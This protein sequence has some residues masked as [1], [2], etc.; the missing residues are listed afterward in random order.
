MRTTRRTIFGI[1]ISFFC[2]ETGLKDEMIFK[3][4]NC[5]KVIK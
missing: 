4:E 3:F 1:Y 5:L 2:S